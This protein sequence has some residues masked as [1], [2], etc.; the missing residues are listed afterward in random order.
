MS[1][2]YFLYLILL[3]CFIILGILTGGSEHVHNS[4]GFLVNGFIYVG[5]YIIRC[6]QRKLFIRYTVHSHK[7]ILCDIYTNSCVPVLTSILQVTSNECL[8]SV[9]NYFRLIYFICFIVFLVF[10]TPFWQRSSIGCFLMLQFTNG[11]IHEYCFI[12][13]CIGIGGFNRNY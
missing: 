8:R 4:G 11:F 6:I 3:F 7:Y 10:R 2:V 13:S 1:K 12:C 5:Y 9:Y